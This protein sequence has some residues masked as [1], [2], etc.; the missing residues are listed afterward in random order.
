MTMHELF[1]KYPDANE[2]WRALTA[3]LDAQLSH[4][5]ISIT[6]QDY[7]FYTDYCASTPTYKG[8]P[9]SIEE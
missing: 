9:F 2:R 3:Y 5:K 6:A 7:E 1:K 4:P 8:I